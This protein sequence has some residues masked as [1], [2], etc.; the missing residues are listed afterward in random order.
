MTDR[1]AAYIVTLDRDVRDDRD[2]DVITALS[3]V[4]GVIG[5]TPVVSTP[6]LHIAEMRAKSAL[7]SKLDDALQ[8]ALSQNW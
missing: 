4:R 8:T 7:G 6:E 2:A 1:H 5:V 3:M